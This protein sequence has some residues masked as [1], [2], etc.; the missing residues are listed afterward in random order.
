MRVMRTVE[1][2]VSDLLEAPWVAHARERGRSIDRGHDPTCFE[3][4]DN[5]ECRR[6][7]RTLM[8]AGERH[9]WHPVDRLA[10]DDRDVLDPGC[11]SMLDEQRHR[12]RLPGRTDDRPLP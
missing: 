3:R 1:N 7:I 5:G 4:V 12:G 8:S 2:H 10:I 11:A 6:R 9:G